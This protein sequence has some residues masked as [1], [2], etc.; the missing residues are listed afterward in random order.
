MKKRDIIG[1]VSEMETHIGKKN[2]SSLFVKENSKNDNKKIG[3][4][5][6]R[7]IAALCRGA[8]CFEEIEMLIRYN[9]AKCRSG[10]SWMFN[11]KDGEL[12]GD[13]ILD[14]LSE[15]KRADKENDNEVRKSFELYFGYLYWQS[16]IW[17]AESASYGNKK[18]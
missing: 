11:C 3:C 5:Q 15:I 18:G 13:I 8:E 1:I 12:F 6:F 10:E 2:L 4:N 14:N 17:A 16:R 7:D 9:M